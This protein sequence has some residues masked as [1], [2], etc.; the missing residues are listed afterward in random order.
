MKLKLTITLLLIA[1]ALVYFIENKKINWQ[2][3]T[4]KSIGANNTLA[5]HNN[6]VFDGKNV[7]FSTQGGK[8]LSIEQDSGNIG[9]QFQT[10]K[11]SPFPPLINGEQV[12]ISSFD[13]KIYGLDKKTGKK[14]WQFNIKDSYLPDTPILASI[15]QELI[16]FGSRDGKLHALNK[17]DGS[18]FWEKE[19][20]KI[21]Q[22]IFFTPETIH[23]GNIY[24]DEK[25]IYLFH[26]LEKKM[27]S[28][29][30]L[31]GKINWQINDLSFSFVAPLFYEET[32]LIE[33]NNN[34]LSIDKKTGLFKKIEKDGNS[35]IEIFKIKDDQENIL[36]LSN[37]K[38]YKISIDLTDTKWVIENTDHILYVQNK[39]TEAKV[40]TV[41]N[42]KIFAQKYLLLEN[43]NEL[44]AIDYE[45]G[46][47]GWT[48]S[49]NSSIND[50]I[51]LNTNIIVGGSNGDIYS[52]ETLDGKI[53]WQKKSDGKI[54]KLIIVDEKILSINQKAG[55][56]IALNYFGDDGK[57]I[58]EYVLDS[59]INEQEIY[60]EN[61]QIYLINTDKN[62]I[63]K[64]LI[65]NKRPQQKNIKKINFRLDENKKN[66]DPYSEFKETKNLRWKI[67]EKL[68]SIN[69]LFNNAKNIFQFEIEENQDHQALEIT[70]KH[71]EQLY[72][73][74]FLDLQIE[75]TFIK[76]GEKNTSEK[77][78]VI[79]G[80]YYD[81]NTWKIRYL[82]TESGL[83]EYKIE[84]KSPYFTKRM[85]G[86][87]EI[88]NSR[89]GKLEIVG[90][91]F[92]VNKEMAFF[93]IG[94]QDAFFDR[95]YDGNFLM[96][97]PDS[98]LD[99]PTINKNEYSYKNLDDYLDMYKNEA[100]LNIFRYGVENWTPQLWE[101]INWQD[102]S[103]SING[104]A[105]GDELVKKLKEKD[106]KVIM[107]IFGFYPPYKSSEEIS[108]K[109]NQLAIQA[110]LDYVI[111]RFGPYVDLWEI[112]N[113]AEP[114]EDWYEFVINYLKNNDPYHLPI[115]TNWETDSAKNLD[116]LS[117]HWYNPIRDDAGFLSGDIS[118]LYK[119]YNQ[120]DKPILISEFGFKNLSWFENS[121]ENTRI[122]SWL[123]VFQK[124]GIIFWTNG[125]NGIY[126]NKD[127]ANIYLGPKERNYLSYLNNFLPKKM[128]LPIAYELLNINSLQTQTYLIKN[129]DFILAY[130]L[131]IDS[132]KQ[133]KTFI[134]LNIEE[135]AKVQW[136]SPKTGLLLKEEKIDKGLQKIEIPN[137][138]VDLA[139]KIEYLN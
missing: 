84:I 118:Y 22:T 3:Y 135:A 44:T 138:D 27:F 81:H 117:I 73:N 48:A 105:F 10:Q 18:L 82:P 136:I 39:I 133:E 92:V 29:D 36:L 45:S 74:K 26:A 2:F 19:F 116:F 125:Q 75:A 128:Y 43:S 71:D 37:K 121:A 52:I 106:F 68:L 64:N 120:E 28:I 109:N 69:Y 65:T 122:L 86:Q 30:Q 80:F 114:S 59:L 96:E 131:K 111:A 51:Y 14:Q 115:S 53:N 134:D 119:K 7:Y 11:Y 70:V 15:S 62:L 91:Q 5:I 4:N 60:I 67:K 83:Y 108:D 102:F 61:N 130:L 77:K 72:K 13:G 21:D 98:K 55:K 112:T 1:I 90:N 32:I 24:L 40:A 110:Y 31:S 101:S 9:W 103:T 49:L 87:V 54:I 78:N 97:M 66:H 132:N 12:F 34:I 93:P 56:K 113:E 38:L 104:G 137:F 89:K 42:G 76:S 46:K 79:K 35:K 63:E 85:S 41:E 139:I 107:T 58:W 88:K 33:Q 100:K 124:M 17:N 94:I 16:F 126:E 50:Q 99:Q 57:K 129:K 47:S 20:K 23:F 6:L 123:S 25:N 95:N 8:T 127:N